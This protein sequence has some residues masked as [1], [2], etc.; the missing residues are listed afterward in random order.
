MRDYIKALG[1]LIVFLLLSCEGEDKNE[2]LTNSSFHAI[3]NGEEWITTSSWA[4]GSIESGSFIVVGEKKDPFY[5]QQE[6]LY[7]VFKTAGLSLSNKVTDF[8]S[9]WNYVSGGDM[10]I[11][12]Y[13]IDS[14]FNNFIEIDSIDTIKNRVVG[15]FKIRLI[16]D[17]Y[18]SIIADTFLFDNGFFALKYE[19]RN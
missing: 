11:D 16:R 19:V 4:R 5:N 3:K 18:R 15:T 8:A 17:K 13:Q 7:I 1:A 9:G 14:T 10:I 2:Q 12:S 6:N